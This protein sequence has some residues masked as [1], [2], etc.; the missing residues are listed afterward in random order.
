MASGLA[1]HQPDRTERNE[2]VIASLQNESGE[3]RVLVET[4]QVAV[5]CLARE[6]D[7]M[8]AA[9]IVEEGERLLADD[10]QVILDLSEATFLDLSVIHALFRLA[11]VARSAGRV[12]VLQLGTCSPVERILEICSV[13]R[14]LPRARTRP[15][16]LDTI[17][18]LLGRALY[19]ETG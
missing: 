10:K 2:L 7:L 15:E 12:V 16:A 5:L 1:D 4:D 8:N 3:L 14:V 18:Q 19:E 9:Q 6:F 11:A 17:H 13:E